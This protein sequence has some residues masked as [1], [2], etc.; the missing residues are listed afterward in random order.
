MT[1]AAE[2]I[3]LLEALVAI[4]SVNPSLVSGAAADLPFGPGGEGAHAEVEWV[5]LS[6]TLACTQILTATPAAFRAGSTTQRPD[7]PA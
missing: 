4:D 5:S 1:G 6:D 7:R 2:V 3:G